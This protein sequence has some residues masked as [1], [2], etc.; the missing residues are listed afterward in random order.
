MHTEKIYPSILVTGAS[1]GIGYGVVQ[2]LV[3]RAYH[4]FATVRSTDDSERLHGV[5]GYMVTTVIM[6]VTSDES[7]KSAIEFVTDKLGGR[8]LTALINNAGIAIG[9]PLQHQP[10]WEVKQHYEVN[11]IG[12]IR[13]TQACLPL[14]GASKHANVP[15]GRIINISSVGGKIAAP[16]VAAYVGTKHAVEGISH[17]LRRELLLYGIKVVIVGP[18]SVSTPIW[19]KGIQL[20]K[21]KLTDYWPIL[22]GFGKAAKKGGE[23]GLTIEYLGEKIADIV[24]IRSPKLRYAYAPQLF[25]NWTIPRLLPERW[26]DAIIKKQ[27]RIK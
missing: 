13:V 10:M 2:A 16:F 14:L 5:F 3:K 27:F 6:D 4:V 7:V 9:G 24:Q 23:Q 25:I 26:I 11:V 20:E 12:L 22:K 19:D 15:P 1:T 17:S 18:G 21:Y 8:G